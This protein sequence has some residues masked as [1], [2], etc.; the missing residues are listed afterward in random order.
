[1]SRREKHVM[2]HTQENVG[3]TVWV[4]GGERG[5]KGDIR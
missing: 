5:S 3:L 2:V 1:M 4:E